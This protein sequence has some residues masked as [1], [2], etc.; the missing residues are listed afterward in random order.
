MGESINLPGSPISLADPK[1]SEAER[2]LL[3]VWGSEGAGKTRFLMSAPRPLVIVSFDRQM[4]PKIWRD[5]GFD[6]DDVHYYGFGEDVRGPAAI[7]GAV[8]AVA[9]EMIVYG[10]G[11]FAIDN[12]KVF[13]DMESEASKDPN[14]RKG[15]LG[16]K[17]PNLHMSS[18]YSSLAAPVG[19]MPSK[20]NVILT[21]PAVD[22]WTSGLNAEGKRETSTTGRWVPHWWGKT[23]YFVDAVLWLYRWP[24]LKGMAVPSAVPDAA[25]QS[26]KTS[27]W[28]RPSKF[29]YDADAVGADIGDPCFAKVWARSFGS[30]PP[31]GTWMPGRKS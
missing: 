26:I 27:Y 22:E 7:L 17:D 12:A 3:A 8:R 15:A 18:L 29:F 31:Q 19:G 13:W 14:E 28:A 23:G 4:N 1:L 16:Y 25:K 9:K 20:L 10:Q 21:H 5:D 2:L 11:T 30:Q 24:T 6:I